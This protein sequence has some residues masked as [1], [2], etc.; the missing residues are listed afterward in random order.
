[1]NS[2]SQHYLEKVVN[3]VEITYKNNEGD[4]HG[5]FQCECG[6]VYRLKRNELDPLKVKN[7]NLRVISRGES[8]EREFEKLVNKGLKLKELALKTNL[9][10]MVVGNLKREGVKRNLNNLKER[11]KKT[12][13]NRT[14][15]NRIIWKNILQNNPKCSRTE[16]INLNP[17]VYKYLLKYDNEWY[18]NNSPSSRV[19]TGK[20]NIDFYKEMDKF[21][22][23]EARIL[24]NDWK[25]HEN[26]AGKLIKRTY[27]GFSEKLKAGNYLVGRK[28]LVPNTVSFILS[29]IETKE[30]FQKRKIQ[31]LF[32]QHPKIARFSTSKIVKIAGMR[33]SNIT[34]QA[35]TYL[36]ELKRIH[37]EDNK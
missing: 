20:S 3:N 12:I 19:G 7:F 28:E 32:T 21:L 31:H 15:K 8:W 23:K 17:N 2:L 25:N 33:F 14:Q 24:Y 1:M 36:E 27:T 13:E 16:L 6:F 11:E 5:D 26:K 35:K 10:K 29:V 4:F 18:Q 30:E 37:N 9:C 22:L 34:E